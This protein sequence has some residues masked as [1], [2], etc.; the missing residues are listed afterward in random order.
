MHRGT[1]CGELLALHPVSRYVIA[2]PGLFQVLCKWLAHPDYESITAVG[3]GAVAA[4]REYRCAVVAVLIAAHEYKRNQGEY[5][6]RRGKRTVSGEAGAG[7]PGNDG[8]GGLLGNV[9]RNDSTPEAAAL[10]GDYAAGHD[11][12][13]PQCGGAAVFVTHGEV[14]GADDRE[15]VVTFRCDDHD[16]HAEFNAA[17]SEEE[18]NAWFGG[19][20]AAGEG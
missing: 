7:G 1:L 6:N 11:I 16:E 18:M 20:S 10:F 19:G 3:P 5:K 14:S 2:Q 8:R 13:C 17:L 15:V 12:T 9:A 4:C